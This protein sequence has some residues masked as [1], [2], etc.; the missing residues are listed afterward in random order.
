MARILIIEDEADIVKIM[1]ML[2]EFGSHHVLIAVD[3][4][5]GLEVARRELPDLILLDIRLPKM[6]GIAVNH[7]LL[8]DEKTKRIPVIVVS[9]QSRDENKLSEQP[10]VKFYL[11]KPF[12][13]DTLLEEVRK[14][15]QA[16][17][18]A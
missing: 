4:E 3:G 11:Q 5:E 15:L 8:Q 14:V 12:N 18:G 2:L 7:H 1:Q 9:T 10:N 16:A 6:D 17:K 13:A